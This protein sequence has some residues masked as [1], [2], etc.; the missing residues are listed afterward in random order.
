MNFV[1][2]NRQFSPLDIDRNQDQEPDFDWLAYSDRKLDWGEILKHRRVVLLAE[3]LSGKTQELQNR[4][5]VLSEAGYP[6]FFV[7]IEDLADDGF[8]AALDAVSIQS[9]QCWKTDPR[10]DAWFFLDSV[11]EARLNGKR[12]ENALRKFENELGLN[13]LVSR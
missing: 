8:E 12:F 4:A 10:A 13:H 11:D 1:D 6:A 9:F 7:R 2:L 3:A 5:K